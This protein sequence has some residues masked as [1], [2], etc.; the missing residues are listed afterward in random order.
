MS[1]STPDARVLIVAPDVE[2][3]PGGVA[4]YTKALVAQ[5]GWPV[6]TSHAESGAYSGL[7]GQFAALARFAGAVRGVDVVYLQASEYLSISRKS[8][9][10]VVASLL[11]RRAVLHLHAASLPKPG[12]LKFLLTFALVRM[13]KVDVICLSSY[14]KQLLEHGGLSRVHVIPNPVLDVALF[15]LPPPRTASDL[16]VAFLGRVGTRKGID[17]LLGALRATDL[18]DVR[19]SVAIAG[20]GEV[21]AYSRSCADTGHEIRFLGWIDGPQKHSL[22]A[23]ADVV[24]LPSRAEGMPLALVEA[25]AAGRVIVGSDIPAITAAFS[26]LTDGAYFFEVGN[27]SALAK[28]LR[29]LAS[30]PKEELSRRGCA[31]RRFAQERL[32]MTSFLSRLMP[33]L[34]GKR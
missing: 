2:L 12:S 4:T 15:N 8:G 1:A 32:S 21:E 9:Y 6:H 34:N 3:T 19:I 29:K 10:A 7:A 5:T 28:T 22:L 23:W 24:C 14:W 31:N 18:N 13:F 30:L 25:A 26:E 33:V 20:D 11:G 17:V 16:K 27:A